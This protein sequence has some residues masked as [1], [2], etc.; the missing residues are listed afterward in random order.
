MNTD[1]YSYVVV[2]DELPN[3]FNKKV[4]D[5]L[6]DGYKLHGPLQVSNGILYQALIKEN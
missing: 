3:Y 2:K 1:S 6:N 4:S 5:L